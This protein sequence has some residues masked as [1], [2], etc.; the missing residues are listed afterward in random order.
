MIRSLNFTLIYGLY[1]ESYAMKVDLLKE[2]K[3]AYFS[4]MIN[5]I[6][7]I[8]KEKTRRISGIRKKKVT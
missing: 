6:S 1:V 5:N 2:N 7:K 3:E 4:L 8:A